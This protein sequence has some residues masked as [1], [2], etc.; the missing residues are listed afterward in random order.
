[1]SAWSEIKNVEMVRAP[2]MMIIKAKIEE[3][4]VK[5]TE[6]MTARAAIKK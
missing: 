5:I 3:L 1:M 2:P 4:L 6:K